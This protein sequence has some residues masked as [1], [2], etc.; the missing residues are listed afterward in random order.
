[1][2]NIILFILIL[3][4]G[5]LVF[6]FYSKKNIE[7][8]DKVYKSSLEVSGPNKDDLIEFS[9]K[10]G[11]TVSGKMTVTGTVK[12]AYFFEANISINLLDANQNVL[13][14]GYGTATTDWMTTGPVSFTANIDATGLSGFGYIEI[15]N[16]DPSDGEGGPAKIILIPVIFQ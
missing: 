13:K 9:V 3:S 7:K 11:S 10:P 8:E 2:K 15:Q 14:A 4:L 16:D 1:M 5:F 12:N 6:N